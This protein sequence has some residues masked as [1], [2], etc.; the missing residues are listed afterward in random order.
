MTLGSQPSSVLA[1]VGSPSKQLDLGGAHE[2]RVDHDVLLPVQPDARERDLAELAHRV[3][4]AGGSDVVVGRV[5]L[6]HP[7][8][9]LDV[10]AGEAPVALGVEVAQA[11]L[12]QL[13]RA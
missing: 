9:H 12:A 10:V 11:Q 5:L 4:L 8:H 6:Q 3:R 13:R 7:P 1:L 2:A